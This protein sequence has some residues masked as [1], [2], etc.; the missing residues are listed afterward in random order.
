MR[1]H[2]DAEGSS[3]LT[4]LTGG[5]LDLT[6]YAAL[7]A[8]HA[9]IYQALEDLAD[10]LSGDP[11]AGRFVFPDLHRRTALEAD[12]AFL[13]ARGVPIPEPTAATREYAARLAELTEWPAGFVAHHYVRYLGDL[14]GGQAIGRLIATEYGLVPGG[15]GVRFYVFDNVKPKPFKD[16]YRLLLDE[17]PFDDAE[18]ERVLEEVLLAYRFNVDVLA[19]LADQILPHYPQVAS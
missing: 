2:Q 8:Q 18:Q 12:L 6:A 15:D 10:R 16:A 3:Y 13:R 14:S 11:V 4:A 9:A 5:R 19:S 17:A 7:V 1:M